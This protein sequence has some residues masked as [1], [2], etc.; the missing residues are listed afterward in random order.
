MRG[1]FTSPFAIA[2]NYSQIIL[3]ASGI[4]ITPAL[5]VLAHFAGYSRDCV[6]IWMV[7]SKSMLTFFAPLLSDARDCLIYTGKEKLDPTE[8]AAVKLHGQIQI[9]STRPN[10]EKLV[11]KILSGFEGV[12]SARELGRDVRASWCTLYCGGS[13]KI[14]ETLRKT[15][16]DLGFGWQSELFD[17]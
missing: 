6:L 2:G 9:Y 12:Q 5:G 16:N 15:A 4:G 14:E 13:R 7:R 3:V 10:L 8:S 1:P 11:N 17:W